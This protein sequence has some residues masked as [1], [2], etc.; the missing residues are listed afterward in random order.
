MAR[1]KFS[2]IVTD[3][4]GSVG[5]VTFQRNKFGNTMREKPLPLNPATSAQYGVRQKMVTIQKAWQD[6][7]DAQ[8][9]QWNRFLDFSGQVTMRNR[10]VKLSGHALYIKYQMLRLLSGRPLLTTIAYNVMPYLSVFEDVKLTGAS[11]EILF[12]TVIDVSEYYFVFRITSPRIANKAFS[13]RG[14][15]IMDTAYSDSAHF[16]IYTSY[17]AAFGALPAVGD[18]VHY[19]LQYYSYTSPIVAGAITGTTVVIAP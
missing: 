16:Y 5:G 13:R 3:I 4:A 14:L 9:L 10:N 6:L 19:S 7:T 12:T 18:T 8:R 11:L 1:V 15:R 2:P 17:A